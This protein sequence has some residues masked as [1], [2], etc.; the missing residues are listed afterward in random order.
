MDEQ[1][2]Q[3]EKK[4]YIPPTPVRI[5]ISWADSFKFWIAGFIFLL[6][7]VLLSGSLNLLR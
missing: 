7:L 4:K 6:V 2:I 5:E 1:S 3:P